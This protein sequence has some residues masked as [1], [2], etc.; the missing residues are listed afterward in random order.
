MPRVRRKSSNLG[1]DIRGDTS[2]P[3]MST[4]NE[5]SPI[6][7]QA[8]KWDQVA[9]SRSSSKSQSKRRKSRS[10]LRRFKDNCLK[11]TWLLPL[12]I[13]VV[14][15]S[16]YAVNP[17]PSNPLHSAIFLSYPQPPK[18]P[19]GPV[20]YGKGPKDI[21][22][23]AFYTIVLSFTREF[24]MQRM[25]R[26]LAVWC[27]IRGKGKTARFMEQVYT[28]IYFA[29][30]GPFGLYVMSR[31]DIWYFNTTAM[32]E[33]FPHREHEALF[34]AYYLLEASYWAQQAIVLMLQLEKPRKDF[35]ELVGHHIITLA[36]IGLSYR[37][38]FTY[39][40]IAVYITHDI[41]DFFLATSK[42]FNYLDLAITAPYFGVFVGVWIYLRHVLN[43]KIL[44]AVLTEFRTVGPF[45]LNWE[46]QQYKCWISQYITFA[47][48]ASLQAVNLFWLFLILRILKN[49]LFTNV[50]KDERSED[51]DSEE[52][53][54]TTARATGVE[55]SSMT[56]RN[57]GK[58]NQAPQVLVNGQP[59]HSSKKD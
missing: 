7:P 31:S 53:E 20:M 52:E 21:A 27:G 43:L 39:M 36:L 5:F 46:T 49:Y 32:F 17:T 40:G 47:L 44:W 1:A 28:A 41:S 18:T 58:E 57:V 22:F 10:L 37:F 14:L 13:L 8:P 51:E 16:A 15:L 12:L 19:G 30:F 38:H 29:I 45:E 56:A 54:E 9:P 55:S 4:M 26:P 34:K 6:E 50:K 48:L 25:I 35:K 42:T 59:L 2:A 3:A 24:L 33:G 11:H 23:V